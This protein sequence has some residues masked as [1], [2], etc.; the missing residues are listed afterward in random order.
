M[1][2]TWLIFIVF[3]V[4]SVGKIHAQDDVLF[5]LGDKTIFKKDILK[6]LPHG[7]E[8]KDLSTNEFN[9]VLNYYL[10]VHNV[11]ATKADTTLAFKRNLEFH[12]RSIV[13]SVYNSHK[14]KNEANSCLSNDSFV[15]LNDLFVPFEPVLLQEIK[16]MIAANKSFTEIAKYA[17]NYPGSSLRNQAASVKEPNKTLHKIACELLENKKQIVGPV[18]SHKGY[19]YFE[20]EKEF[21]S[22]PTEDV[23]K[24]YS[25]IPTRKATFFIEELKQHY[26]VK[27]FPE[28]FLVSK[29]NVLFVIANKPYYADDLKKYREEYGYN[30]NNQTYDFFLYHLL[31]DKYVQTLSPE[32]YQNL[33]DDFY[34]MQVYNPMLLY[35]KKKNDKFV[36]NLRKLVEK[37]KP[38][39]PNKKYVENN[40][41][42]ETK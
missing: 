8:R 3:L 22:S 35:K 9:R 41:V 23:L 10:S 5:K 18:K 24:Q 34:F 17:E 21:K 32:D 37:Y 19:H 42:F 7:N 29:N 6:T 30:L 27:E 28:N 13:G 33:L 40:P 14:R 20:L 25:L 31:T 39:I 2:F 36:Q 11:K 4:S 15:I 26:D 1:R 12:L 16:K 38:S